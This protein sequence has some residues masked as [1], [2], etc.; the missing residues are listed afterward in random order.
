[1]QHYDK[2]LPDPDLDT[3]PFWDFCRKHELRAQQC[4][5]CHKFRWPPQTICPHCHGR[6][7]E[8]PLLKP[9][10]LLY[11]FSVV[12]HVTVPAFKGDVPFVNA[13]AAIDGT[14]S[15]VVIPGILVDCPHENVRVGMKLEIFFEDVDESFSLPR[16]RPFASELAK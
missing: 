11:S 5:A 14:D 13:R 4:T 8:W 7:Y 6:G 12:H 15:R 1:M 9:A 16:F 2:P 3:R 10:G